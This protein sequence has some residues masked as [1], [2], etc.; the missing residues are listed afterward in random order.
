ML[1]QFSAAARLKSKT[2]AAGP[3]D[4][5]SRSLMPRAKQYG[6]QTHL[7]LSVVMCSAQ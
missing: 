7:N 2:Q 3:S 6:I 5:G 1:G 4:P